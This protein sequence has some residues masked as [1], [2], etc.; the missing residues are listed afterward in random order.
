MKLRVNEDLCLGCGACRASVQDVFEIGDSG[1]AYVK[2][3][4]V[5]EE[6]KEDAM[7][8]MV[9]CPT[10]AIEEVTEDEIKEAA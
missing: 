10:G 5:P 3:A 7:D 8:A 2:V 1:T 4:A 6:L 9:G